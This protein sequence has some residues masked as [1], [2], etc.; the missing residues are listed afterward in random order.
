MKQEP[1]PIVETVIGAFGIAV[2]VFSRWF[3]KIGKTKRR[4]INKDITNR[5]FKKI[6]KE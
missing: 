3:Y 5:I 4:E 2:I 1:F 6:D